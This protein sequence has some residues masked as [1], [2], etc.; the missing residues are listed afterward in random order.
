MSSKKAVWIRLIL[1]PINLAVIVGILLIH[2]RT[3]NPLPTD[4]LLLVAG[5]AGAFEMARLFRAG[6][7]ATR[8]GLAALGAGLAA[9]VGLFAPY[10]AALRMELR[11]FFVGVGLILLLLVYLRD[12]RPTAVTAIA[13]TFVPVVYVGLL[14]GL[15]REVGD[16]QHLARWLVYVV[17]VAKASD[18]GGWLAGKPF[19]RHKMIPTVS[20]G[21]S[22]EGLAGG[23]LLSVLA[24]LFVPAWLGLSAAEWTPLRRVLFGLVLGLASVLAGVTHSG[25]KRRLNAKDSSQLIPE[26]GGVLDLIDSMLFAGPAA[27]LW[28][29]LGL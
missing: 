3:G 28:F 2:D 29:R 27:W 23:L 9:G 17:V 19:G 16:G 10:D 12:V 25:W 21:K 18:I 24:A 7:Y 8:P 5:A 20:P 11:V 6:G 13:L 1:S 15:G 26:I 14:L 22:W 4:L